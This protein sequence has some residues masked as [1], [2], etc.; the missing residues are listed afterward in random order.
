[1]N[2]SYKTLFTSGGTVHNING[3]VCNIHN[4]VSNVYYGVP[5]VASFKPNHENTRTRKH[6]I[7]ICAK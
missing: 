5:P 3:G 4:H 6:T 7:F 2:Q 1:M